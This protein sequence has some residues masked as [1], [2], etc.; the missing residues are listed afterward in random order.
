M[1]SY[2][3]A[4]T[5]VAA[6]SKVLVAA[7]VDTVT[8]DR[9]CEQVKVTNV[10]GTAAIYF[11]TDG[12]TPTVGGAGT[13]EVPASALASTVVNRVVGPPSVVKLISAGTPTYSVEGSL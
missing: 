12:S 6:Y 1:A 13:Y 2:A 3:V 8:I 7:T 11:T 5:E 9:D 10:T 4:A